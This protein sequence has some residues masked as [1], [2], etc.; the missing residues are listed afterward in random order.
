MGLVTLLSFAVVF[1]FVEN[2]LNQ[3]LI[4]RIISASEYKNLPIFIAVYIGLNVICLVLAYVVGKLNL[5]LTQKTS[6]DM[7]TFLMNKIHISKVKEM[8]EQR[9]S[10]YLIRMMEDVTV[11]SGFYN[12]TLPSNIII[13]LNIL[14]MLVYVIYYYW[15]IIIPVIIFSAV[16]ILSGL[17]FGKRL[18]QNQEIIKEVTQNHVDVLNNNILNL[19]IIKSFG[20]FSNMMRSYNTVLN[21][22]KRISLKNYDTE[23]CLGTW[24]TLCSLFSDVAVIIIGCIG[25]INSNISL[26]VFIV[27]LSVSTNI[28]DS[29]SQLASLNIEIQKFLVSINRINE[30]VNL[31]EETIQESN[32]EV[33]RELEFEN[34]SFTYDGKTN[35]IDDFSA[36]LTNKRVNVIQ[37]TSGCGKSTLVSLITQMNII[38]EGYVKVNN[39][40]IDEQYNLREKVSVCFQ[41]NKFVFDAVYE[42]LRC[43]DRDVSE[44][45]IDIALSIVEANGFLDALPKGKNSDIGDIAKSFSGGELQRIALARTLLKKADIYIFDESFGSIDIEMQKRVL[46][47]IIEYLSGKIVVLITHGQELIEDIPVNLISLERCN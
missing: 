4:D 22:I 20:L 43:L 13:L 41:D 9:S 31:E 21:Q 29:F 3:Y 47:R 18:K 25:I 12:N 14:I 32:D 35:A 6:I 44:E 33:V 34:V 8:T 37:G 24:I 1:G 46:G 11:V 40:S 42:N 5:S 23:F 19:K 30:I 17:I 28:K 45:E 27:V 2:I 39:H 38:D 15:M 10:A 26:G 36:V 7:R 16:Q